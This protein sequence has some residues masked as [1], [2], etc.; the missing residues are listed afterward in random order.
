MKKLIMN[1]AFV[2]L[3]LLLTAQDASSFI[4]PAM[5]TSNRTDSS[6]TFITREQ[7]DI[8]VRNSETSTI[9]GGSL[10]V[11]ETSTF[12]DGFNVALATVKGDPAACVVVSDITTTSIGLCRVHGFFDGIRF[13]GFAGTDQAATLAKPIYS[14]ANDASTG[15][16]QGNSAPSAGDVHIGVFLEASTASGKI[17][18]YIYIQ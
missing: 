3:I 15:Q 2:A 17:K 9:S 5:G 6:G 12:A 13:S 18:S 11:W 1:V 4:G 7:H 8:V 16:V 10:V 14:N